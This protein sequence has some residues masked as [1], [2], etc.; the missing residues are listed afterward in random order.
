MMRNAKWFVLA[1]VV[2]LAVPVFAGG[3]GK[4]THTTQE[5]LDMY[6]AKLKNKGWVGIEMDKSEDKTGLV[7]TRVV[8]GSP[9]EEAGLQA[10]DILL[11]VNGAKYAD[12]TEDRCATCEAMKGKWSPGSDVE[13]V[14]AR[15]GKKVKIDLT[16]GQVPP[17]VMAQWLGHHMLEHATVAVAQK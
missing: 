5:C 11:A 2:V 9:A 14:V 13:Y 8:P 3:K 4:C 16:L 7:I 6:A 1:L 12:N 17:D 15:H 10:D